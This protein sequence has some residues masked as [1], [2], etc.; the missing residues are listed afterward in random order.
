MDTQSIDSTP[1]APVHLDAPIRILKEGDTIYDDISNMEIFEIPTKQRTGLLQAADHLRDNTAVSAAI[2]IFMGLAALAAWQVGATGGAQVL[3]VHVAKT[4]CSALIASIYVMAGIPELVDL[5]FNLTAGHIDTHV[6]MTLAV[7]GTLAIGSA[8]EGA[9]LMVLFQVSHTVEHR[10]TQRASGSLV[11][12]L[13]RMPQGAHKLEVHEDGRPD[14]NSLHLVPASDM[15]PGQFLLVRPGEQVPLDGEIVEGE[16]MVS[17]ELITGESL[18]VHKKPGDELAAGS[19]N[20]D[21][22]LVIKAT[23]AAEDSTPARITRLAQEAQ[24]R[25][26]QL[27]HW[28]DRFG[29]VYAK[30]V[31]A[32]TAAALVIMPLLGV[33]L[34]GAPGQRGAIYRAMGLLTTASPCALVIVPLAYVSAIASIT[35]RGILIK[36]GRVLDALSRCRT[37]ALD[38]TGT[39]T[40]GSLSCTRM[41]SPQ[42]L[43]PAAEVDEPDG[44]K[45]EAL[46]AGSRRDEDIQCLAAAVALSQMSSHP[47]SAAVVAAGHH[48]DTSL[49][50][51]HISDFRATSGSGVTGRIGNQHVLF[52]SPRFAARLLGPRDSVLVQQAADHM[53]DSLG[54][55]VSVFV[56]SDQALEGGVSHPDAEASMR[57][58]S[59]P[60]GTPA[61]EEVQAGSTASQS[62]QGM[63]TADADATSSSPERQAE[64]PGRPLIRLFAF[65][66]VVHSRSAAALASL[67]SGDWSSSWLPWTRRQSRIRTLMLTGDNESTA[68]RVA[69]ELSIQDFA[70]NLL[71]EDKLGQI[72][73]L[74]KEASAN[75]SKQSGILMVGDGINDA[76]ALAAADVGVAIAASPSEA[77][78]SSADAVVLFSDGIATLPFLLKVAADTQVIIAQNLALAVGSM[79]ALALPSLLGAIPLGAAVALHEGSTLLVALNCL[80]LLPWNQG[81][82]QAAASL[83]RQS[84]SQPEGK[85]T[86]ASRPS[87]LTPAEQQAGQEKPADRQESS[88]LQPGLQGA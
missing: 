82:K 43:L 29:E 14:M 25:K 3:P 44:S 1:L 33:P 45:S 35:S 58:S 18:P 60:S 77:T 20:L 54:G 28:L 12:L 81:A 15:Q 75:G 55:T 61:E 80:R 8:L 64:G 84:T 51:V 53:L 76:P 48:A 86:S 17:S 34:L 49:P 13:D 88:N 27:R 5:A 32:A 11:S 2:S 78:A 10:L 37:I 6:L 24:E 21:G 63:H 73:R 31:I 66:D 67:H 4:L 52:G 46:E 62:R 85:D 68:E 74:R 87:L 59:S 19:L 41:A 42:A 16:A 79:L 83:L 22:S 72:E 26:P 70:A 69:K 65:E 36:G 7:F 47:V 23:Q 9:L 40:T 57:Q 56:E 71:P 39:L 30:C 50:E 38:K